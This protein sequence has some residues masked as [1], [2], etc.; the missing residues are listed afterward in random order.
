MVL[1][2]TAGRPEGS[3]QTF[4]SA[5]E[6]TLTPLSAHHHQS[7]LPPLV[8][9]LVLIEWREIEVNNAVSALYSSK[10]CGYREVL[11]V[12]RSFV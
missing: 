6:L 7:P 2:L 3:D 4:L 12:K 11:H 1:T 10:T 9:P 8:P 5:E